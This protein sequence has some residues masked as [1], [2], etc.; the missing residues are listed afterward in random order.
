MTAL[1]LPTPP[2][3]A[4][5]VALLSD[6]LRV[7][8]VAAKAYSRIVLAWHLDSPA[9]AKLI[10]VSPRTWARIKA[11]QWSGR[12]NQD[13]LMRISALIGLYKGLHL[14]FGEALADQWIRMAN[15][16]PQFRGL[17]P[18]EFMLRGGLP[19]LLETRNY[20]DALRGGV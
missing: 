10:A 9:A 18:V 2:D 3:L 13:Q 20:I 6:P 12:L 1:S 5:P 16:G 14:Y 7:A 19:A 11:G 8:R 17:E 15:T 4:D